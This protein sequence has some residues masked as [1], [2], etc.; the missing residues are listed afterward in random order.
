MAYFVAPEGRGAGGL[1][2]PVLGF[3]HGRRAGRRGFAH[4]GP[5]AGCALVAALAAV[6]SV[7][8]SAE[9]VALRPY[10]GPVPDFTLDRLVAEQEPARQVTLATLTDR[11]V[12]VH[13]FA[14]WC[15]PCREELPAL[16]AL[17]GRFAGRPLA[18]VSIDAGE[19]DARVRRFLAGTPVP[20]PVLM[21]R[22][23]SVT[24]AWGIS[25][26]PSTVVLD[27]GLAPRFMAEGEVDWELREA[28]ALLSH[29]MDEP[30]SKISN[31]VEQ[32]G[33]RLQ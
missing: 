18:V 10:A 11:V 3:L 16:A 28:D 8:V 6:W 12:V 15:E 27:A 24:K 19:V 2:P 29:L 13:F 25:V 1:N 22:D 5:S 14:T 32:T 7:T 31:A 33:G 17:A 23:R 20:F 26:L 4:S 21:D 9:P 30:K